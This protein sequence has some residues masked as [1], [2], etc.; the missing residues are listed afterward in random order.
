MSY[1]RDHGNTSLVEKKGTEAITIEGYESIRVRGTRGHEGIRV[2]GTRVL[3]SEVRGGT[4]GY[5]GVRGY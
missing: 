4:K 3:E 2:W 5:E 1:R